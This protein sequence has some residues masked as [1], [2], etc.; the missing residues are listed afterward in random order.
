MYPIYLL[1]LLTYILIIIYVIDLISFQ[2]VKAMS[3]YHCKPLV[4]YTYIPND[5]LQ[6]YMF[7]FIFLLQCIKMDL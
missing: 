3:V 5:S 4:N 7:C 6:A 2:I 1:T